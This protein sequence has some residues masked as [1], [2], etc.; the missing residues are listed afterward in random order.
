[1][2]NRYREPDSSLVADA[3]TL[4]TECRRALSLALGGVERIPRSHDVADVHDNLISCPLGSIQDEFDAGAGRELARK[5]RKPWSSS[6]LCVNSF[7]RWR[8]ESAL[9][10]LSVAGESAFEALRFERTYSHGIRGTHPHVDAELL[11]SRGDGVAVVE[12]KCLEPVDLS[13]KEP[14]TV[15]QQYLDLADK[16]DPRASS[17]WYVALDEVY[18]YVFLD[19]YQLI[20]HF[21]GLVHSGPLGPRTIIYLYWQPSNPTHEVFIRHREEVERFASRVQGD[22]TCSFR[23]LTYREHWNDL[24]KSADAPPWLVEHLVALRGRYAIPVP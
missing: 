19:S 9:N 23:A 1:M 14:F 20:K 7:C 4:A 3:K 17:A 12:S 6:A 18:D 22:P 16:G 5:M 2:S 11:R 15:S 10:R 13:L 8:S 24:E 21:L